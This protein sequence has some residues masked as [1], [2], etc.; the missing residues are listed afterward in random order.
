MHLQLFAED[1]Q[2]PATPRHRQRARRRGQ[3]FRSPEVNSAAVLLV[4]FGILVAL[5]SFILD[6]VLALF[7]TALGQ[8]VHTPLA[9]DSVLGLGAV[10]GR[11]WALA[12][13]PILLGV[14]VAAVA[15]NAAQVGLLFTLEPLSPRFN[16]INPVEGVRRIFSRRSLFELGKG[17]FRVTLVG[18]ISYGV[19]RNAVEA[20][21]SRSDGDIPAI[22]RIVGQHGASLAWRAIGVLAVIATAD[23]LYQRYEHERSLMMTHQQ[24]K[25]EFR[26]TEGDPVLRSRIRKRQRELAQA[27]MLQEVRHADVVVVNPTHYAVALRYDPETMTAPVCCAKGRDW[28][29]LRI[30]ELAKQYQV[31]WVEDRFLARSLYA[32]VEVGQ[33]VP[34]ALYGAVAE[35]LAFV[36]RLRG[37]TLPD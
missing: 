16:R 21:V 30:R 8:W 28:L 31:T 25:D 29:A 23:Y 15:A 12:M 10:A 36:W 33:P 11:T 20:I 26:E 32:A 3:V 35:V 27:R 5:G 17:I 1:K 4:S 22:I 2:H 34:P 13:L 19:L 9:V 18:T 7:R 37:K 24:L 6:Q 14:A